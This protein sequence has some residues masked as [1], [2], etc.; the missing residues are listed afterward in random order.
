MATWIKDPSGC[1][2][3]PTILAGIQKSGSMDKNESGS[4]NYNVI[5]IAVDDSGSIFIRESRNSFYGNTI[6]SLVS[7]ATLYRA[8][9]VTGNQ[10]DPVGSAFALDRSTAV[11]YYMK[12][13][14]TSN[15]S[16][17]ASAILI[18][19]LLYYSGSSDAFYE[20]KYDSTGET[21]SDRE[22]SVDLNNM[23]GATGAYGT[24]YATIMC[25]GFDTAQIQ[26][27]FTSSA[28]ISSGSMSIDYANIRRMT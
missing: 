28:M 23:A 3:T 4:W 5:P 2:L 11:Q 13:G 19:A 1:T 26:V 12:Y 17:T 10:Y 9:K 21:I 20:Q 8:Y 18:R 24:V 27:R 14:T 25:A 16:A 6:V 22:H 15:A 7:G